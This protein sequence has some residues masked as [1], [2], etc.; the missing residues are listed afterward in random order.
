MN[1]WIVLWVLPW[2]VQVTTEPYGKDVEVHTTYAVRHEDGKQDL[3]K[4]CGDDT[5]A[6][7]DEVQSLN[8]GYI[9]RMEKS[10]E[11]IPW[12]V[13]VTSYSVH[14]YPQLKLSPSGVRP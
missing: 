7:R 11:K 14:P 8:D 4:E 9:Q 5:E 1:K 12:Q 3:Y 10:N 6:C 2:A 13:D